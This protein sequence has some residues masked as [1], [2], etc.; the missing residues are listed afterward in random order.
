ML[1]L[2][3]I[4]LGVAL[5]Y[6]VNSQDRVQSEKKD[7]R[8]LNNPVKYDQPRN[9]LNTLKFVTPAKGMERVTEEGLALVNREY[10]EKWNRLIERADRSYETSLMPGTITTGNHLVNQNRVHTLGNDPQ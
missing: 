4:G 10:L 2:V 9:P 7:L 8:D 6:Y 5:A 1:N 3:L